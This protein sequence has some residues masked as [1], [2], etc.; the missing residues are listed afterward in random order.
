LVQ[1][2]C[3]KAS[4]T[5]DAMVRSHQRSRK[6]F[7]GLLFLLAGIW[8]H[9]AML[10]QGHCCLAFLTG[11]KSRGRALQ[12]RRSRRHRGV[13]AVNEA[14]N[15]YWPGCHVAVC[16]PPESKE[17][18]LL[19]SLRY[20]E[21]FGSWVLHPKWDCAS[22]S[23]ANHSIQLEQQLA[24]AQNVVTDCSLRV[25]DEYDESDKDKP[26]H[27]IEVH[28]QHTSPV[29]ACVSVTG[30]D[31]ECFGAHHARLST[32]SCANAAGARFEGICFLLYL[33]PRWSV[34]LAEFRARTSIF[35]GVVSDFNVNKLQ[36]YSEDDD[37][38][39]RE[40]SGFNIFQ[41]FGSMSVPQQFQ[42]DSEGRWCFREGSVVNFECFPLLANGN[43]TKYFCSQGWG[44]VL[45]HF[46][47]PASL[48]ACDFD[49]PRG[50]PV[51]A[52]CDGQVSV[53][54]QTPRRELGGVDCFNMG[55]S[56]QLLLTTV[57]DGRFFQIIYGHLSSIV[58]KT[59]MVQAGDVIAYTGQTGFAPTEH[60][61]F[62]VNEMFGD[63]W[64]S[65]PF[66]IREE[67]CEQDGW[68][69]GEP[70]GACGYFPVPKFLEW[71]GCAVPRD[72]MERE[73]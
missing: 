66:T 19:M 26:K 2:F 37:V 29:Y 61:H 14:S 30:E 34:R 22:G 23:Q 69:E 31:L 20:R 59:R 28:N 9:E 4:H 44:G 41:F 8:L 54:D 45:S 56:K 38:A 67:V 62:E 53:M 13:R 18:Q 7:K 33:G 39:T 50:T 49:A 71:D 73:R 60:L 27:Y 17:R 65:A 36:P 24:D 68:Y 16:H 5:M 10:S 1:L 46:N 47:V 52:V 55:T 70:A 6:F 40:F 72:W 11:A 64:H 57:L 12:T 48:F 35:D 32:A 63:E 21:N 43:V 51:V 25:V 42:M 58:V 15:D 3:A